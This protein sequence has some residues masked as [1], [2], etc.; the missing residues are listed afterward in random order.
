MGRVAR[1]A[2]SSDGAFADGRS[3]SCDVEGDKTDNWM[4]A[5][6]DSPD[7]DFTAGQ[8]TIIPPAMSPSPTDVLSHDGTFTESQSAESDVDQILQLGN[9][10]LDSRESRSLT[11]EGA[12]SDEG[13]DRDPPI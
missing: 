8:S 10:H 9:I 3:T 13:N 1:V 4:G 12:S 11:L 5:V 7:G 2:D 6:A